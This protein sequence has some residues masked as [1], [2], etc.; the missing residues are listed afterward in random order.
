MSG[1]NM[2]PTLLLYA[3]LHCS[4]RNLGACLYRDFDGRAHFYP[5]LILIGLL[6]SRLFIV[7]VIEVCV[8]LFIYFVCKL[9]TLAARTFCKSAQV[10]VNVKGGRAAGNI[11]HPS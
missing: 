8:R 3:L 10:T 1:L 6:L 2:R 4:Y 9:K 7:A 5:V 11:R